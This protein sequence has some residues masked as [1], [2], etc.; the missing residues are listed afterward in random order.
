MT[1]SPQGKEP[2]FSSYF[3]NPITYAGVLLT[4][5][6]FFLE[7]FLFAVD[8][9]AHGR[10]LYLGVITYV[11]LPPFLLLGLAIIPIGA[12]RRRHRIR[13]GLEKP[14]IHLYR[15]DLTNPR[16][17]NMLI[18]FVTGTVVLIA[19]TAAMTLPHACASQVSQWIRLRAKE[20]QMRA[21]DASRHWS[22]IVKDRD[23]ECG[24]GVTRG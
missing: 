5:I 14:E 2:R 10:N 13:A 22:E 19:G 6:A 12:F 17:R 24:P 9:L 3:Y 18:T 11:L 16:H 7:C 23:A 1:N 8:F 15:I 4:S 20:S 21:G